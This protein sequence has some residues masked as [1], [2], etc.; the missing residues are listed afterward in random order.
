MGLL[1]TSNNSR[2]YNKID[3]NAV[4]GTLTKTFDKSYFITCQI[5]SDQHKN[6]MNY[7]S[8]ISRKTGKY[9]YNNGWENIDVVIIQSMLCGDN[10]IMHELI[11]KKDYDSFLGEITT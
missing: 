9:S 4:S 6:I 7:N 8:T 5:G 3:I 1:Y 11:D 2:A 10:Y